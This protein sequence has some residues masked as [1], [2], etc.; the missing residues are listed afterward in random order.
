MISKTGLSRRRDVCGPSSWRG[1]ARVCFGEGLLRHALPPFPTPSS[2][3]PPPPPLAP[4][5]LLLLCPAPPGS[6][7]PPSFPRR[8]P[9]HPVI[10]WGP[11][12]LSLICPPL[13]RRSGC[14]GVWF[15]L[16]DPSRGLQRV[17]RADS[18][19]LGA[20]A[21]VGGGYPGGSGAVPRAG[22]GR[23]A[24]QERVKDGASRGA[25][26]GTPGG[27]RLQLL[28]RVGAEGF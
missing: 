5:P 14:G 22:Q 12:D 21:V 23:G 27:P 28:P 18:H 26:V 16:W 6:P 11:P 15:G 8:G 13:S 9:A 3:S 4:S 1:C 25:G 7:P 17:P 24:S 20:G 10:T 19:E 2:P